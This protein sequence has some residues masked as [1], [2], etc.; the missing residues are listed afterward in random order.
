MHSVSSTFHS[1]PQDAQ[2][3]LVTRLLFAA[4]ESLGNETGLLLFEAATQLQR[5]QL[6]LEIHQPDTQASKRLAFLTGAILKAPSCGCD[7]GTDSEIIKKM[8]EHFSDE[9]TS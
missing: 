9:E 3:P 7:S 5:L 4:Q 2:T 6:Q 8:N 1:G